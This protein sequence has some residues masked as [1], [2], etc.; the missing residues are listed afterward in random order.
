MYRQR[1][2]EGQKFWIMLCGALS[3]V[4]VSLMTAGPAQSQSRY[5]VST[6]GSTV[7]DSQTGLVWQ[8][9]TAGQVPP[10]CMGNFKYYTHEQALAYAATQAGAGWRLPNIKELSSLVDHSVPPNSGAAS[11][12]SVAFPRTPATTNFWSSTPAAI[13]SSGAWGVYFGGGLVISNL[14][15]DTSAVRLVR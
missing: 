15:Y 11:I 6:D 10:D 7:T 8:R 2:S 5:T 9:C 1:H 13:N 12:D 3:A 14:R 4:L